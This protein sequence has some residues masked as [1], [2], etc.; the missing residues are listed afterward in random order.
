[1]PP[2]QQN[3]GGATV[4]QK[5]RL[6]RRNERRKTRITATACQQQGQ[7][8]NKRFS[9]EHGASMAKNENKTMAMNPGF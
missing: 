4:L 9:F 5:L 1:M 7:T 8:K 6:G 2:P 3:G